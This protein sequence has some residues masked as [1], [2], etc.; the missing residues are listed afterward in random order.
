M[1]ARNI[2]NEEELSHNVDIADTFYKR[3]KGLLGKSGL[4]TGEALW[5][6]PCMSVHTFFMK[7]PIDVIFLNKKNHVIATI[8]NLKP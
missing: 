8:K 3:M 7:F 2:R 6:K 4:K 1:R 5:I